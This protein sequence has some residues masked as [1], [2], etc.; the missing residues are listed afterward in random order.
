VSPSCPSTPPLK[1]SSCAGAASCIYGSEC[2]GTSAVCT[3][4]VWV[5]G[6]D[7]IPDGGNCPTSAPDDGAACPLCMAATACEYNAAC[8]LDAG[9]T[10][11]A[12]CITGN[13][14]KV[15]KVVTDTCEPQDAAAAD[16][17]G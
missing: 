8:D 7:S 17:G 13:S 15:W 1:G 3:A 5:T 16:G 12:T 11:T 6:T 2:G 10:V 4:G 9:P 14:G